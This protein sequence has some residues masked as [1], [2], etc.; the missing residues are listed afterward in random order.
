MAG[1]LKQALSQVK[2]PK[3]P[4]SRLQG[5]TYQAQRIDP[6]ATSNS[7][8]AAALMSLAQMG[9]EQYAA[10]VAK[11]E[12]QGIKRKNEILLQNLKPEQIRQL[13]NDGTLLYQDDPY[14]M[15]ALERELG[16]QEAFNID[17]IVTN[18]IKA[19]DFKDRSEME[20]FRASLYEDMLKQSAEA[21]G[22]DPTS[23]F[24]REGLQRDIVER[25]MAVYNTQA[26]K[27]DQAER[28]KAR[29]VVEGNVQAIAK[30]GRNSG[31]NIIE[32]LNKSRE[33]GVIRSDSEMETFLHKA[34]LELSQKPNGV[35]EL[36][37]L[38][39]AKVNL[40]GE[41]TT[42][43]EFI[44]TEAMNLIMLKAHEKQFTNDWQNQE[45][46][47]RG[48]HSITTADVSDPTNLAQVWDRV[49]QMKERLHKADQNS[50]LVTQQKMQLLQ[51]ELKLQDNIAR[52]VGDQQKA[53][54]QQMQQAYRIKYMD[55]AFQR[56]MSGENVSTA[57][58]SQVETEETGKW[59]DQDAVVYADWKINQIRSDTSLTPEEQ[60][61]QLLRY[62]K[63]DDNGS[64][65]FRKKF[66][67]LVQDSSQE[68]QSVV[69]AARFNQPLPET[70]RMNE[71][72][73][74]YQLDSSTIQQLYPEN[75]ETMMRLDLLTRAGFNP[76]M[77]AKAEGQQQGLTD[78]MR[79]RI[80]EDWNVVKNNSKYKELS[81]IPAT[82]ENTMFE[83][84]QSYTALTGSSDKAAEYVAGFVD[85]NYATITT[86]SNL[87]G[88]SG[89]ERLGMLSKTSLMVDPNN[90]ESYKA[91]QV[92]LQRFLDENKFNAQTTISN[93]FDGSIQILNPTGG[94]FVVSQSDLQELYQRMS[95]EER[96]E[97]LK[98]IQ[99][100]SK[101]QQEFFKRTTQG[102]FLENLIKY[103]PYRR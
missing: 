63:A 47:I 38:A 1:E 56:R 8:P 34:A 17:S 19:G 51:A 78:D 94:N 36:K 59:S 12:E 37:Q 35:E 93:T 74:F 2:A 77:L 48:I 43:A 57:Y 64:N 42:Y 23:K 52:A 54:M 86:P 3:V 97:A 18:K 29:L 92:L 103:N 99:D 76:E 33:D 65:G 27:T 98:T 44:G 96:E 9:T 7:N 73:R 75:A 81:E 49:G 25:N 32:Y 62:L 21:Y 100:G 71:L 82:L 69:L 55:E 40:W 10:Y 84:Y 61:R 90:P 31:S 72:M 83:V 30:A 60:D 22:I 91:G 45:D 70:P 14:A 11:R 85:A 20:A 53:M 102:A 67:T 16:R 89:G 95:N 15:R 6:V 68:W 87:L 24:F 39:N 26:V 5:Q 46:F 79:T 66:E 41:D 58:K 101:V 88:T 50:P 4:I 13:R 80:R 28:N